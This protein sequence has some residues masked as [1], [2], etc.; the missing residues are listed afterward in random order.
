MWLDFPELQE[1]FENIIEERDEFGYDKCIIRAILWFN[2]LPQKTYFHPAWF[3]D[4]GLLLEASFVEVLKVAERYH[5][6]NYTTATSGGT[7]S[8]VNE[9]YSWLG[10]IRREAQAEVTER[11]R[12]WKAHFNNEAAYSGFDD[13]GVRGEYGITGYSF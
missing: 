11:S 5:A 13:A 10:Q 6:A 2:G 3:P 12:Q 4:E 9:R 7:S 8:P 1:L